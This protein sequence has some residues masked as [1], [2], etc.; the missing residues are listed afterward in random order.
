MVETTFKESIKNLRYE[1]IAKI[2]ILS[3]RN[4]HVEEITY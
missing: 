3:A 2:N 4:V 1:D